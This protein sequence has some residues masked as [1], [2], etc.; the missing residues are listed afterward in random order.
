MTPFAL[1]MAVAIA[2]IAPP[3]FAAQFNFPSQT[4][5]VPD[6]FEVEHVAG[7]PLVERP[8]SA[9]F[10]D[11]GRLYVTDSTGSNEKPDKQLANP[12]H[13]VLRLEDTDGDGR[14]DKAVVFADKVMFPQGC[15]WYD[16]SVYV[17]APPSIWKFT[18]T[19]ADGVADQREEWFKGGTL[20]GCANDIH[21][22]YLGPDGFIYWT[23]GAFDEQTHKLENGR[24][25]KDR[26]AHIYRARPN[27][28]GLDV[29]M[30]GGMDNPVEIAFTP[31]GE[32]IFTS[33]FIDFTQP[34]YR[35]GI[36]HA[37]YGGV[38][39]KVNSA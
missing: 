36:G 24:V 32:A 18:D 30:S 37:V 26:A 16:G 7:T 5:T 19:D 1:R 4:F 6:G 29:I 25:L 3:A 28:S 13:R 34:G 8:V 15:L 14:F 12:S 22:P 20:T 33:T 10:D 39:G 23:K 21:G 9:S 17:A 31:E 38:F 2:L 35:D 27:G 11:R